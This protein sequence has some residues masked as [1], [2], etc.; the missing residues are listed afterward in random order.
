MGRE[1]ERESVIGEWMIAWGNGEIGQYWKKGG[2][3]V[4]EL[5]SDDG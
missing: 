2:F 4:G 1:R 5:R 3:N